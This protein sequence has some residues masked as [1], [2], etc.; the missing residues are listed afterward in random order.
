MSLSASAR[1]LVLILSA[2][3]FASCKDGDAPQSTSAATYSRIVSLAPNLTEL[4][5]AV[6]AGD[7]LVGVSAYSDY[8]PAARTLPL[9]GDA[10]TVDQERLAL[11]GPDL[12]LVWQ[13]G[14][15]AHV[16][17]ELLNAGFQ[18]EVLRTQSLDDVARAL[19]R[20]GQ[21]TGRAD[22]AKSAAERYRREL[23]VLTSKY[24][25]SEKIRVFYQVSRRP[26]YTVNGEHYVS[27]LIERCGGTNVFYD[28]SELA[29]AIAVEAVIERDP[30]VMLASTDAGS[31]AFVEW[32]RW[33]Q[34]AANRLGNRFIVPA[35]EIGRATTRLVIAGEALCAAL[36]TGRE[37]RRA[38]QAGS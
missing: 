21:L 35:D 31:D 17:D 34:I 27:E 13:S 32:E 23:H 5:Y 18:V 15:P 9:I 25:G 29:P 38:R 11:L 20:I 2:C 30:E 37:R 4:V 8:P 10:F 12:L 22:E 26:L 6:G 28:L 33:P 14:T 7:A 24:A 1:A 36:Q 16:V 19:L 3:L